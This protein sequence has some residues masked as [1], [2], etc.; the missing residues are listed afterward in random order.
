[1]SSKGS[2]EEEGRRRRRRERHVYVPPTDDSRAARVRFKPQDVAL[3]EE[4]EEELELKPVQRRTYV[5]VPEERITLGSISCSKRAI[6]RR[7]EAKRT[8]AGSL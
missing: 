2:A 1:M 4:E 8:N 3:K 6:G 7:E 5:A